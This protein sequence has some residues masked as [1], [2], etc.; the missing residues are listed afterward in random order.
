MK[1]AKGK[2]TNGSFSGSGGNRPLL[3]FSF[4][5]RERD[6]VVSSCALRED[7]RKRFRKMVSAGSDITLAFDGF[8]AREM[9]VSLSEAAADQ[10]ENEDLGSLLR[11][12][13][14]R[15]ESKCNDVFYK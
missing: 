10:S 9:V 3:E 14:G 15:F 2:G 12:L 7:I 8:E 11:G 4:T 6:G 1:T 13:H 5:Q